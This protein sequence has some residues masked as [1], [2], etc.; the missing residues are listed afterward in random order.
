M[1]NNLALSA[2]QGGSYVDNRRG[3][4]NSV[5]TGIC[6][7]L[8]DGRIYPYFAGDRNCSGVDQDHPGPETSLADGRS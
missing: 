1:M 5:V 6:E 3:T 2:L 8:H 7:Q 4:D